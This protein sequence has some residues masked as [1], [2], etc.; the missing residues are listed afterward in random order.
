[1]FKK[2][3]MSNDLVQYGL[4][5]SGSILDTLM[6]CSVDDTR[7]LSPEDQRHSDIWFGCKNVEMWKSER[8][9][10]YRI[11][12]GVFEAI[13]KLDLDKLLDLDVCPF[14]FGLKTLSIE[15]PKDYWNLLECS[16]LIVGELNGYYGVT[17]QNVASGYGYNLINLLSIKKDLERCNEATHIFTKIIFGVLSIGENP[18]IVKPV[19]LRADQRKYEATG[20]EKY[21]EKAK[22]RGVFGFN[23]GEDIPTKAQIKRMIEENELAIKQGR[24]APHYRRDCLALV[25]TGKGR[26]LPKIVRRKG[27]F[28]NRDLL[29]K[30]PQG[31]Y[32]E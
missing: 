9:P 14:P 5:T 23:I 4:Y 32:E 13:L 11:Y 2:F 16:S 27:C 6:N 29:T 3:E 22:R 19:V 31:F 1:M 15:I 25:Y 17:L 7:Q 8:C 28:V 21:I 24:K 10:Y 30:L 20:D 26:A 12:P 18:D